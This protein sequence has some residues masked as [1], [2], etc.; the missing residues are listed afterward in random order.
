MIIESVM[1]FFDTYLDV[2]YAAAVSARTEQNALLDKRVAALEGFLH[3][4]PGVI[5]SPTIGRGQN[6][7]AERLAKA[8]H[9][10]GDVARRT[11][12]LV[13]EYNHPEWRPLYAA[14]VSGPTPLSTGSYGQ[15]LCA[16]EVDGNMKIISEY[17]PEI[18]EPAP[19]MTWSHAQGAAIDLPGTPTTVRALAAPTFKEHEEDWTSMSS[20]G[21]E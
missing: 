16:T 14:Y 1:Q 6:W 17:F 2:E 21:H 9:S 20:A 7:S 10:V 11:L 15:L 13:A 5:M 4:V 8:S 18:L 3:A 19:P 12:F